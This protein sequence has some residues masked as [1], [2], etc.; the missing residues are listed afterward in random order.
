MKKIIEEFYFNC[1]LK[2]ENQIIGR[3]Y[4]IEIF[5][6]DLPMVIEKKREYYL[7]RKKFRLWLDENFNDS[8]LVFEKDTAL[9]EYLKQTNQSYYLMN[10]KPSQETIGNH[11]LNSIFKNIC[12]GFGFEVCRI[13]IAENLGLILDLQK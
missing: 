6:K 8:I 10:E 2:S 13:K 5:V 9:I 12:S 7:I 4:K 3:S 1:A 11:L